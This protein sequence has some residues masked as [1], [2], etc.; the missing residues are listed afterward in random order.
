MKK[1]FI[2]GFVILLIAGLSSVACEDQ[3]MRWF[4]YTNPPYPP[5]T[6]GDFILTIS[7]EE[8]TLPR[9]EHYWVTAEF[10]NQSGKDMEIVV[11]MLFWPY[12]PNWYTDPIDM[13]GPQKILFPNNGVIRCEPGWDSPPYDETTRF[14]VGGGGYGQY[15]ERHLPVGK[16]ELRF[17]ARFC[18]SGENQP[19]EIISNT[20]ELTVIR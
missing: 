10:K 16:H 5:Q 13:P 11:D 15:S 8:T 12:I 3:D 4:D 20:I 18:I 17:Y 9:G 14:A 19:I 2:L 7:V 6:Q 1:V